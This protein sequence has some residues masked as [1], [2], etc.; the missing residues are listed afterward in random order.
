MLQ[1]EN[2]AIHANNVLFEVVMKLAE[3]E[4]VDPLKLTPPL[5]EVIDLDALTQIVATTP[6]AGQMHVQ[7]SFNYNGHEVTVCADGGVS[8]KE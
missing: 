1:A 8:V 2:S 6:S 4:G 5:F 3:V 7:V